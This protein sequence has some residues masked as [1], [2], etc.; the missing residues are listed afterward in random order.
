MNAAVSA[1]AFFGKPF[2]DVGAHQRFEARLADP[3]IT[4]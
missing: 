2:D 1:V 4:A 3:R